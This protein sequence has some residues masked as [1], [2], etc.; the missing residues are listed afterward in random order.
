MDKDL[1]SIL[2]CPIDHTP[3]SPADTR[4]IA[5]LN[6]AI[7]AGRVRNQ[8]GQPVDQPVVAGLVRADGRLLYPIL[9]EIPVLLANEAI[10]LEG[11]E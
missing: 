5:R 3:L 7:A 10:P 11:I 6:R 2:V 8:A 9:E 1:L 4:L